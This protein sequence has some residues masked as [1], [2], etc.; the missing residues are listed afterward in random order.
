MKRVVLSALFAMLSACACSSCRKSNTGRNSDANVRDA[1]PGDAS[2]DG[3]EPDRD[4]PAPDGSPDG[5]VCWDAVPGSVIELPT[6][7]ISHDMG[8]GDVDFPY[9]VYSEHRFDPDIPRQYDIFLFDMLTETEQRLTETTWGEKH[10][11][12][13]GQ[14]IVWSDMRS[15]SPPDNRQIDMYEYDIETEA[16]TRL[17]ETTWVN[18]SYDMDAT[19][20]LY[21][22]YEGVPE[23]A[24][25]KNLM[26]WN[27]MTDEK[28][29][30]TDYTSGAGGVCMS[31]THVTWVAFSPDVPGWNKQVYIHDIQAA[32]TTRLDSTIPGQQFT[33]SIWNGKLVWMDSRQGDYDIFLYDIA[34]QQEEVVVEDPFDQ[35]YGCIRNNLLLYIDF[36]RTKYPEEYSSTAPSDLVVMDLDKGHRRRVN[37]CAQQHSNNNFVDDIYVA[38]YHRVDVNSGQYFIVD[39]QANGVLDA[40]LHVIPNPDE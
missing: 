31:P 30:L 33:T 32:E 17:T 12:M 37:S 26:L 4:I 2:S 11:V 36:S 7:E 13:H 35:I 38:Y 19:H 3:S 24:S 6:H 8:G 27:R 5:E 23:D 14:K 18:W 34:T 1:G 28:R 9:V 22:S 25:G 39:L 16:L 15:Y 21:T 40:D 20:L 10:P 29:L